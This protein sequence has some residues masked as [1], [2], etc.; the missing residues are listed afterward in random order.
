LDLPKDFHGF[1][2]CPPHKSYDAPT[3]DDFLER[4]E[5]D[6]TKMAQITPIFEYTQDRTLKVVLP[7]KRGQKE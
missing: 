3:V 1:L 6:P 4:M 7:R 2:I 5:K